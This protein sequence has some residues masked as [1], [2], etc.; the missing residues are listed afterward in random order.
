M[1][2]WESVN[3]IALMDIEVII[4]KLILFAQQEQMA[5]LA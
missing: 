4:V 1:E 3:V 5:N 2:I